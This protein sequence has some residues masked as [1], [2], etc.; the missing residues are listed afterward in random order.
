[1]KLLGCV[2]EE[3]TDSIISSINHVHRK[4]IKLISKKIEE[5]KND[6]SKK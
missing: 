4:E 3:L 6:E 2:A 5:A 1:M